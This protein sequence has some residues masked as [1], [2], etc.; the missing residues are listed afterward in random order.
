M[1]AN[2]LMSATCERKKKEDDHAIEQ[3]SNVADASG[4]I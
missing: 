1:D 2:G 3:A 4:L